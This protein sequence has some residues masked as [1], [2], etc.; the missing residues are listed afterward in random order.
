MTMSLWDFLSSPLISSPRDFFHIG[1]LYSHW[2][3]KGMMTD[4]FFFQVFFNQEG[5]KSESVLCIQ[6]YL[7]LF[8]S[9]SEETQLFTILTAILPT[10]C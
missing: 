10:H 1:T 8:C 3:Q 6:V 7:T 2:L 4:H 9:F 5:S